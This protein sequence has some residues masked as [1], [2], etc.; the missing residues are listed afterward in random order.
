MLISIQNRQ[1]IS[2]LLGQLHNETKPLFGMM[3]AQHMVEHLGYS[4]DF[5]NGERPQELHYTVEKAQKIR[6][7]LLD[8]DG[9]IRVGF[10]SPILP[11]DELLPLL[12]PTLQ[13]AITELEVAL[14]KFFQFFAHH[15]EAKPINPTM[16]ELTHQEWLLF[17]NKHFYHHFSQFGLI[18]RE[19]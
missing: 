18:E 15:P 4:V 9:Q 8:T 11:V 13:V 14:N 7:Y 5:S 3:T 1:Q 17:H 10:K 16:G 6:Q 12:N 2:A 19:L